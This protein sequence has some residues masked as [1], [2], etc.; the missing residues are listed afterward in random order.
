MK[1]LFICGSLEEG[2]DGVGDYTRRLCGALIRKGHWV[3]ILSLCDYHV[4]SLV[5]QTQI[6][7]QTPIVVRRIPK[8]TSYKQRLVWAQENVDELAPDW[9]SLQFVLYSFHP[10]GLPYWL[11]GFLKQ[12]KGKHQ[13]QFMFHELW[14]GRNKNDTNKNRIVSYL[15]QILIKKLLKGI[16]P[17]A[18]NTHL[19]I[20]R[21]NLKEMG[22]T[23]HQL[24][25]FSNVV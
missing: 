12:L 20:F 25:L 9:I 13:W 2:K 18:I 4:S 16:N 1:F 5:K 10:K 3:E 23:A 7:E 6:I 17:S 8:N 11:E 14:V 19:P 22:Y 24:P 15:Q 21:D